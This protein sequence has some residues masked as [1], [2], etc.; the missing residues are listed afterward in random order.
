MTQQEQ[1]LKTGSEGAYGS[2]MEALRRAETSLPDLTTSYDGESR[3][4]YEKIVN[5]PAFRYEAEATA[6]ATPRAW[7]SSST[8]PTCRSSAT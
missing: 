5:R 2:T 1:I 7:D 6:R 4:L 8:T 3:S